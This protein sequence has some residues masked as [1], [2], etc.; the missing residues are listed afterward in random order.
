[1]QFPDISDAEQEE[2]LRIIAH[3]K[4][5]VFIVS[6]LP[7][8]VAVILIFISSILKTQF[9]LWLFYLMLFIWLVGL[10]SAGKKYYRCP[11]CNQPI[12]H[13][14]WAD[15]PM[16]YVKKK[17]NLMARQCIHCGVY[18]HPNAWKHELWSREWRKKHGQ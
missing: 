9:P 7:F 10:L 12:N 13:P 6:F 14:T 4:T 11:H 18:L 8:F 5:V 17:Q 15:R 3:K 2:I 1:M 16:Q